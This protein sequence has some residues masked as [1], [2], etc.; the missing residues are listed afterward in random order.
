MSGQVG[1]SRARRVFHLIPHT[2]WDREWYL[3][4]AAFR[5]RLVTMLDG[6][7]PRLEANPALRFTLDGQT[8]LLEDY[9][10]VRPGMRSRVAR[11]ARAGQLAVGPWYVLADE[12]IPSAASLRRNLML[13]RADARA[14]GGGMRVLYSPDAF[15]HPEWLPDLAAEF[16]LRWGVVWR[17]LPGDRD[18][19]PDLYRWRGPAGG[20]LLIHHLPPEGYEVAAHLPGLAA[21]DLGPAWRR[22][23]DRLVRRSLTRHVAVPVGADHHAPH[24][25]LEALLER[26]RRIDGEAEYRWSRWEDY[27][28]GVE[29]ARVRIPAIE[30][31]LRDGKGYAWSLQG[32]HGSRCRMKRLHGDAEWWL[33]R[34]AEP[35]ARHGRRRGAEQAVLEGAWRT[36]VQSQFHDTLAGTV[37]DEAAQEQAVRL[38][39]VI[40]TCRE[41]VRERLSGLA[42]HDPDRARARRPHG[43]PELVLW[44]PG[45][46]VWRGVVTAEV[47]FFRRDQPVGPPRQMAVRR[48]TGAEPFGLRRGRRSMPVQVLGVTR[49]VDRRDACHHYPDLDLVDRV[50]V[51]FDPGSIGPRGLARVKVVSGESFGP[52]PRN[53]VRAGG[54][55]VDNGL[56]RISVARTG[57]VTLTDRRTGER[58]RGCLLLVDEADRGDLY[59]PWIDP[60]RP[61]R[62]AEVRSVAVRARGPLLGRLELRWRLRSAGQ[63]HLS[64][65][66]VLELTAGSRGVRCWVELANNARGHR[67]RLV[68]ASGLPG[69]ALAGSAR[70]AVRRAPR[71]AEPG[72]GEWA[73][74]TASA[75]EFVAAGAGRRGLLVRQRGSFE[76]QLDRGG[77]LCL[78]LLRSVGQLSLDRLA[79]R[80]GHAAWPVATPGAEESGP[81]L[82]DLLIAPFP[83]GRSLG[84]SH[85]PPLARD[86]VI[87]SLR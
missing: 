41:V 50:T 70:G 55:W 83:I 54:R 18:R 48:G 85:L 69:P 27:F 12:L 1:L 7:I 5:V 38:D 63:G 37:C 4:R 58:Y 24:P 30:G 68:I 61:A 26:L 51:A 81:H 11:L 32:V 73:L 45:T 17:G 76:Y 47:P 19:G 8:V 35:L 6:L 74:G 59:T 10:E 67:L 31:E 3:P 2:H 15:G 66:T 75:H 34:V 9:F 39:S 46:G 16:G 72:P 52:R 80:P 84:R 23:R 77:R 65:V 22:L 71:E 20:A 40:A 44:N 86:L 78:T 49:A 43:S 21:R 13:G 28:R 62:A 25:R 36:L 56:I 42:G 79:P 64:G 33:A 60:R 82:V 14:F 53:P 57:Q 29:R 87:E